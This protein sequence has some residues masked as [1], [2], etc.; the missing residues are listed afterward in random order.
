MVTGDRR[1]A[2][3]TPGAR[4]WMAGAGRLAA[5]YERWLWA[6]LFLVVLTVQWPALKGYYYKAAQ[7]APPPTSIEWRTDLDAALAE[8]DRTGRR[9]LV[10]FTA[11]WCPPCIAMKHD[12]WPDDDVERAVADGYVPV[13]IDIDRNYDVPDRFGVRGIPTV[14]VL[15]RAGGV[16]RRGS[17]FTASSMVSFLTDAR[18]DREPA[19]LKSDVAAR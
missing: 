2:P 14:L 3:A 10:D 4:G 16:L 7:V 1:E 9:V 18:A 5:R 12:V 17:F 8:A 11:D 13:L 6:G 19:Q 15:D